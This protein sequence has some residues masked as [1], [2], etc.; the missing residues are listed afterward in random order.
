MNM[1]IVYISANMD[2]GEL[3]EQLALVS[4]VVVIYVR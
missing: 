2:Q 4:F 3:A 1:Y